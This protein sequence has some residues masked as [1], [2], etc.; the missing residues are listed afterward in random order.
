MARGIEQTERPTVAAPAPHA[1]LTLE[2]PLVSHADK[3][4]IDAFRRAIYAF[5]YEKFAEFAA[6]IAE[7]GFPT[8]VEFYTDP[9]AS[10][11]VLR[12]RMVPQEGAQW[13]DAM[14]KGE[15]SFAL[16]A[17]HCGH[18]VEHVTCIDPGAP[19]HGERATLCCLHS[20]TPAV[21]D[22]E[23]TSFLREVLEVRARQ[24]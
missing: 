14:I 16:R 23:L 6:S 21:L 22:G 1:H 18:V 24:Q 13:T 12:L 9:A 4:F 17:I 8:K 2:G 7:F 20:L 10:M 11:D 19:A 15:C 3:L 5:G